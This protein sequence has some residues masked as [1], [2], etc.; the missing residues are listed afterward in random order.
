LPPLTF[1]THTS[2]GTASFVDAFSK[3]TPRRFDLHN[4][5]SQQKIARFQ[6]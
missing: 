4:L 5:I 2:T 1:Y 6:I 3:Y